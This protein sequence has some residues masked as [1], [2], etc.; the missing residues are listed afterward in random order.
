M[1][2]LTLRR[3]AMSAVVHPKAAMHVNMLYPGVLP[4]LLDLKPRAWYLVCNVGALEFV[5]LTNELRVMCQM[6]IDLAS[7]LET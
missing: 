5:E 2:L 4:L 1:W 3:F 7:R 6:I